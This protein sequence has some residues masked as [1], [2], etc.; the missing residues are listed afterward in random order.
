MPPATPV[1]LVPSRVTSAL[2]RMR[3]CID[4]ITDGLARISE[5]CSPDPTVY[6]L[7]DDLLAKLFQVRSMTLPQ[8]RSLWES[9]EPAHLDAMVES[10]AR[11][12]EISRRWTSATQAVGSGLM[13]AFLGESFVLRGTA[14]AVVV[15]IAARQDVAGG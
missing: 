1:V 6:A 2:A 11:M 8:F 10:Y 14:N 7:E 13:E 12:A 5:S 3:S 4:E 15:S 9:M